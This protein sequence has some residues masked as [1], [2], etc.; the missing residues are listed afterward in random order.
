MT[1]K[2]RRSGSQ[3]L[4]LSPRSTGAP[5]PARARCARGDELRLVSSSPRTRSAWLSHPA[6]LGYGA[7]G[8]L[9]ARQTDQSLL[10]V[11]LKDL[12][13]EVSRA[14]IVAL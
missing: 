6:R 7:A 14:L 10:R 11:L 12:Y 1:S 8:A 2:R 9:R 4:A 5:P 13:Q 3:G